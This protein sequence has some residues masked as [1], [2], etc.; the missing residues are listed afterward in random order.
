[1]ASRGIALK[2]LSLTPLVSFFGCQRLAE[3]DV[4]QANDGQIQI[5]AS[6][7]GKKNPCVQGLYIYH[8]S[9]SE[10]VTDWVIFLDTERWDKCTNKFTYPNIPPHY[11]L[12]GKPRPLKEGEHYIASIDGVGFNGGEEFTRI[13]LP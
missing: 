9:G 6:L 12:I 13:K 2:L 8:M 3:V 10:R 4:V 5:E 11:H 1:M 7:R